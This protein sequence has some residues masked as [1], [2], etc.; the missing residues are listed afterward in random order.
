MY[1]LFIFQTKIAMYSRKVNMQ[2]IFSGKTSYLD[3]M[4]SWTE[5]VNT[6][7]VRIQKLQVIISTKRSLS[8]FITSN[9]V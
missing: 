7:N 1:P 4:Y 2:S 9:M 8:K 3:F 6:S 5:K